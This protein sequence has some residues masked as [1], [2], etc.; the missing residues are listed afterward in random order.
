VKTRKEL[1]EEFR[2]IKYRMGVFRITN[3]V[4]GKVFIGS[5]VD[6]VAIW[7][8]QKFQLN[9]GI[10][11]NEQ[12]Q[13]DWNLFGQEAFSYDILEELCQKEG[14]TL[15]IGSELSALEALVTEELQPYDEKGYN[16][17]KAPQ[18]GS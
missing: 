14:E 7:H 3:Q 1:R 10:H 5:S 13:K 16:R 17:R 8:A 9:A 4:N 18:T 12:L 15:D 2:L 6:L 11:S